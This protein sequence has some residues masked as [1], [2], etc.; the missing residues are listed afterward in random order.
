M[1]VF[2]AHLVP[3]HHPVLSLIPLWLEA[4]SLK[5]HLLCC[6]PHD[7]HN[8]THSTL[9]APLEHTQ[10]STFSHQLREDSMSTCKTVES[11]LSGTSSNLLLSEHLK[12][13]TPTLSPCPPTFP[14]DM[15]ANVPVY[16][17]WA[18]SSASVHSSIVHPHTF[19]HT[20]IS[21]F[22]IMHTYVGPTYMHI[23][24]TLWDT[25]LKFHCRH[26]H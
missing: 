11:Y 20:Y 6:F 3:L 17:W 1:S 9:L 21:V 12:L 16:L 25:F 10:L 22:A 19:V 4:N 26:V 18:T 5:W 7:M 15:L 13:T 24:K 23:W 8:S 14:L 2:H